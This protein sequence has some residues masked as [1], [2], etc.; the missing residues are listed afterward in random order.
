MAAK[1]DSA[2]CTWCCLNL[3]LVVRANAVRRIDVSD[4]RQTRSQPRRK[5]KNQNR[6]TTMNTLGTRVDC[7]IGYNTPFTYSIDDSAKHY[8]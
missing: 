5:R 1:T 7:S 3:I 6:L 8:S 2:T 4:R